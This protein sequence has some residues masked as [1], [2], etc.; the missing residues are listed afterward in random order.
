MDNALLVHQTPYPSL[1]T[2]LHTLHLRRIVA[3]ANGRFALML[4]EQFIGTFI[5]G[6]AGADGLNHQGRAVAALGDQGGGLGLEE[7]DDH[8]VGRIAVALVSDRPDAFDQSVAG[9]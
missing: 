5:S 6:A 3:P 7:G 1:R 9:L 2:C 4:P 8:L